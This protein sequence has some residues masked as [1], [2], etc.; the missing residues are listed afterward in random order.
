MSFDLY[1]LDLD[2]SPDAAAV[3]AL[4]D[5]EGGELS[6]PLAALVVELEQRFPDL[7]DD[8]EGSP[9]ASWPLQQPVAGGRGNA[10]NL[11]WGSADS[12][13][14]AL[15]EAAARHRLTIFDPQTDLLVPPSDARVSGAGRR[16]AETDE[17]SGTKRWWRR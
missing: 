12:L 7:E 1:V 14:E 15:V 5:E 3:H 16:R 8:P 4:I 9:W 10:F 13:T 2:G 6:A 11:T 17:T